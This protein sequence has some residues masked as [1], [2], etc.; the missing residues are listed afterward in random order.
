MAK[1]ASRKKKSTSGT[2]QKKD[3]EAF[4]DHL[5]KD[6]VL[7]RKLKKG[8]NDVIA[9]GKKKGFKFTRQE[10]RAHFKRRYAVGKLMKEDEPDTCICI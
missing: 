6:K 3:A 2:S 5:A 9:A 8:W 10:L 4:V 1:K 7:R